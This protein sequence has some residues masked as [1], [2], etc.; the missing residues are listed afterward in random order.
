[1]LT[2]ESPSISGHATVFR[3]A[4]LVFSGAKLKFNA[5]ISYRGFTPEVV[6]VGCEVDGAKSD[7]SVLFIPRSKRSAGLDVSPSTAKYYT[8]TIVARPRYKGPVRYLL[9]YVKLA[10]RLSVKYPVGLLDDKPKPVSEYPVSGVDHYVLDIAYN[11][12]KGAEVYPQPVLSGLS[13][14]NMSLSFGSGFIN[15][16][17]KLFKD[18]STNNTVTLRATIVNNSAYDLTARHL[19]MVISMLYEDNRHISMAN[20]NVSIPTLVLYRGRS[21]SYEVN[22]NLPTWA[23]GRVTIAHAIN[24]HDATGTLRYSGGPFVRFEVGRILLP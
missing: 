9:D 16:G 3:D 6:R 18:P 24:F 4:Y 12:T 11:W 21:N 23:H 2:I 22:I 14:T 17:G 5:N 20:I 8:F 19:W 10:N 15:I 7:E 13:F 1:M